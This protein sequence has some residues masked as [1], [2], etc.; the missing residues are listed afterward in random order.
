MAWEKEAAAFLCLQKGKERYQI[1][2]LS[3]LCQTISKAAGITIAGNHPIVGAAIFTCETGLHLHGLTVN[4]DTYEPYPPDKVGATRTLRFGHK[5]GKRALGN[6]LAALGHP[7]DDSMADAL[8]E[9]LRTMPG[10]P[11]QG[12]SN[13]ELVKLTTR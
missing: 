4:P 9:H 6:H 12:L 13:P 10:L 2:L 1:N 7:V 8:T 3:R 11:A 5:S